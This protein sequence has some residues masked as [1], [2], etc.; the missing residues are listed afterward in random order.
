MQNVC[1]TLLCGPTKKLILIKLSFLES[2]ETPCILAIDD[3]EAS[4]KV[5]ELVKKN[6][7][8]LKIFDLMDLNIA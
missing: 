7:S 6:F 1:F 8:N 3:V 2:L 4:I 5:A